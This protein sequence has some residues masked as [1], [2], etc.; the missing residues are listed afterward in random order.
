MIDQ[1]R[2]AQLND[3]LQAQQGQPLVLDVREAWEVEAA[4]V[5][6]EDGFELVVMPMSQMPGSLAS[7]DPARPVA[8]LCHHGSRSQRV[9]MFLAQQGFAAVANIAGGIDLWSQERDPG[10]PRY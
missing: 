5:A 4:S 1:V 8:V 3:W 2:P 10:V 7:L 6:P 9:A